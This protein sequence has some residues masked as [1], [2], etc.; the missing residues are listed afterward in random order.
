MDSIAALERIGTCIRE[1]PLRHSRGLSGASGARV[2]LK[3]E[4]RQETGAFKLR[5]AANKLLSLP[6]EQAARGIVAASNGN[7]ALAVATIGQKLGIPVE[8]FV[9]EN[10]HPVKRSRIESLQ[11]RVHAVKGDALAAELKARDE[12]ERS[13][14]PYVS[15]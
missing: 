4:N 6:K 5:G 2:Y 14:R 9:S 10:L 7:H 1:T 11:A 15:P 3:L 13:G 8:I 12:A